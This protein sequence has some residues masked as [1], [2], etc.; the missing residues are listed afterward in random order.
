MRL[1]LSRL[2]LRSAVAVAQFGH[3]ENRARK[4]RHLLIGLRVSLASIQ[5]QQRLQLLYRL[6]QMVEVTPRFHW[7]VGRYSGFTVTMIAS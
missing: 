1:F 6:G 7:P 3:V 2:D 5:P 4:R